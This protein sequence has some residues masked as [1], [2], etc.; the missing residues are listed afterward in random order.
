MSIAFVLWA[1][2]WKT[3]LRGRVTLC[4]TYSTN[5]DN[6]L[7]ESI[8]LCKSLCRKVKR[9]LTLLLARDCNLYLFTRYKYFSNLGYIP[10]SLYVKNSTNLDCIISICREFFCVL[11]YHII[12]AYSNFDLTYAVYKVF[13][14]PIFEKS[15]VNLIT[16]PRFL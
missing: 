3:V 16:N 8:L 11:G 5:S 6:K 13:K 10:V 1:E 7:S 14:I 4:G 12:A 2:R 15:L 9:K